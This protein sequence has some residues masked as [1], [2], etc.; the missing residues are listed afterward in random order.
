MEHSPTSEAD[1]R[2]ACQ[3]IPLHFATERLISVS[4]SSRPWGL[5]WTVQHSAHSQT[6]LLTP[7]A[8][9]PS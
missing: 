2:S 4:T 6:L 7:A 8:V 5:S 1:S 3:E 9:Q